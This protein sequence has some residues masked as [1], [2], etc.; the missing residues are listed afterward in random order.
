ME[1]NENRKYNPEDHA[2]E[3]QHATNRDDS[4]VNKPGNSAYESGTNSDRHDRY[5]AGG[6]DRITGTTSVSDARDAG[7]S[8]DSRSGYDTV[9]E[10]NKKVM[11]S[12]NRFDSENPDDES[13]DFLS[14]SGRDYGNEERVSKGSKLDPDF[15]RN[16]EV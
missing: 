14:G 6:T 13:D 15:D 9:G 12:E 4:V 2:S 16:A 1:N 7:L 3:Q 11:G 10:E 8:K 5:T